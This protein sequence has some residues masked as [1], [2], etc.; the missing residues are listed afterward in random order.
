M[1][2]SPDNPKKK[3]NFH[4]KI[5]EEILFTQMKINYREGFSYQKKIMRRELKEV[6][7]RKIFLEKKKREK[8]KRSSLKYSF[9]I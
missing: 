6:L 9:V 8:E 2:L 3:I 7:V 5:L 1:K 4:Q